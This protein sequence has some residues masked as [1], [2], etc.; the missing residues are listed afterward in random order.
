MAAAI[1]RPTL[2]ALGARRRLAGAAG[3]IAALWLAV[4]WALDWWG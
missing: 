2:L 4:S 3:L 1:P